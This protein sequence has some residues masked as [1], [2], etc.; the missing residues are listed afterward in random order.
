MGGG[1]GG[2][3]FNLLEVMVEWEEPR[4]ENNVFPTM[5]DGFPR[6]EKSGYMPWLGMAGSLPLL[7]GYR[8]SLFWRV[9]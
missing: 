6:S 2:M 1:D 3:M 9:R 4:S 8:N 7:E 5:V